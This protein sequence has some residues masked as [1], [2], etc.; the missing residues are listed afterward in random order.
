VQRSPAPRALG[1]GGIRV[2]FSHKL[3]EPFWRN[4]VP[5]C[6]SGCKGVE[7]ADASAPLT[8]TLPCNL[9]V[10]LIDSFSKQPADE[11]DDAEQD[12]NAVVRRAKNNCGWRQVPHVFRA[13][14]ECHA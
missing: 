13:R 5:L 6:G 14:A 11:K 3:H 2:N 7:L 8:E 4:F 1:G 9:K 10:R 12:V